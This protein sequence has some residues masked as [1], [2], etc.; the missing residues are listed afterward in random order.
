M[1]ESDR[2]LDHTSESAAWVL[3]G[4]L[5]LA[6]GALQLRAPLPIEPA[7]LAALLTACTALGGTALFYRRVRLQENFAIICIGLMQ[8]LLF[9]AI[10]AILSYLLAREGG[11]LWDVRLASWDRALGFDW[12]GY[13]HWVDRSPALTGLLHLSYGSMIPQIIVLI[14]ALGF[15]M[16]VAELRT[17]MF[18]AILCGTV[19]ILVS[20]FF[21]AISRPA[22]LGIT[23]SNFRN[24]DPWGGYV[25]AADLM[26]LRAGTFAELRLSSMR[27]IITFPSYHAG[28]SLVTLWGFWASRMTWLRWPGMTLA[29]LTIAASPVDGGHYLVDVLAGLAIA[30]VS[31]AVAVRA[32]RWTPALPRFTA[33]PSRRSRAAFGR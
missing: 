7:S 30:A 28:L 17:V 3:I 11:A 10:G 2:T 14:L 24:V 23:G 32:V 4:G 31:I 9:S 13:L 22:Y 19:C 20:A 18:A 12:L 8:V 1:T 29:A 21:P 26:S 27:G 25:H 33:S 15:T 16:R 5:F 6:V